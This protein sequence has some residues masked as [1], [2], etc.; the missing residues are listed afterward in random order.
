MTG[1]VATNIFAN[2]PEPEDLPDTS[3][4]K[5]AEEIIVE[6]ARGS[7]IAGAAPRPV[8]ARKIVDAVLGGATGLWWAGKMS[9]VAYWVSGFMPLW[10]MVSSVCLCLCL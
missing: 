6:K 4:W 5:P 2:H 8:F 10:M 1:T 7:I 9:S 3:P